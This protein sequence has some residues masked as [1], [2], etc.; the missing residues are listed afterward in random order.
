MKVLL[1]LVILVVIALP[2]A[3]IAALRMCFQ[4]TPLLTINSAVSA[5]DI[6][7]VKRLVERH[8]P[9]KAR[10][11]V[12]RAIVL[13]QQDID[14]LFN[15]TA[16]HFR[17]ASTRVVLQPGAAVVQAS[18]EVPE[19]PFGRW[20][21][22]EARLRETDGLPFIDHLKIGGLP[23][24]DFFAGLALRS[25]M[26]QLNSTDQGRIASDMVKRVALYEGRVQVVYEW[27]DDIPDRVRA[28]LVPQADQERIKA[29]SDRL[30]EFTDKTG[31]VQALSLAQLLQPL[32]ALAQ[33]RSAGGNAAKENRA[34]IITLAFYTNGRGLS[35]LIPA[36]GTWRKP[37]SRSVTLHGRDDF[38]QHFLISA[39]I[40]AEAGS[41]LADA[42]GL[43]K[44]VD[45]SRG[46][47]GFSFNDIAA[48][49]AGTRFGVLAVEAPQKLQSTLAAG[50]RESDFMPSVAGLPEFMQEAQFR[51]RYG[52]IGA[53]NYNKIMADIESRIAA[54][55]LF[56]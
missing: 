13:S 54:T 48:D 30:V 47:T 18:L 15:Y 32:F 9:R 38:P 45:D 26:G 35:A 44:E 14:L 16:N 37:A 4:A 1:R 11:G 40:A 31:P 41:P 50:V 17:K 49:R 12:M 34:A 39:A 43:Y 28:S 46:G 7:R 19:S 42:I 52:G 56:R 23:V 36:A 25:L 5:T 21:N 2:I 51:K 24:P 53:P 27:R 8:D 33:Q 20:L 29:Y 6:E 55:P 10:E 22:V 3:A